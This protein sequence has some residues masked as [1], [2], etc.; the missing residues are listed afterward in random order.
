MV[1]RRLTPIS[2][3]VMPARPQTQT[4][5]IRAG[6]SP[7]SAATLLSSSTIFELR[8]VNGESPNG[9]APSSPWLW[10]LVKGHVLQFPKYGRSALRHRFCSHR[11]FDVCFHFGHETLCVGNEQVR[12][13]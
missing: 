13:A 1:D 4:S 3:V 2:V 5:A 7:A 11:N 12:T 9:F 8:G 10:T 6:L